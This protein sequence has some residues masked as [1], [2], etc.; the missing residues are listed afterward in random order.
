MMGIGS[1]DMKRLILGSICLCVLL[2]G[3]QSIK[4]NPYELTKEARDILKPAK[5]E[6]YIEMIQSLEVLVN[7][8]NDENL[9][10]EEDVEAMKKF[11]E[12]RPEDWSWEKKEEPMDLAWHF[13]MQMM[14]AFMGCQNYTNYADCKDAIDE[15]GKELASLFEQSYDRRAALFIDEIRF[16]NLYKLG[17]GEKISETK[18]AF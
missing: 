3:C 14:D 12:Q 17:K 15:I 13:F 9:T 8:L 18:E 6:A 2:M 7:T 11:L 16:Y 1:Y 10:Y 4:P 5:Q